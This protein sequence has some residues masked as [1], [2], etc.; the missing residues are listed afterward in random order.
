MLIAGI[1]NKRALNVI[2]ISE[3]GIRKDEGRRYCGFNLLAL[4]FYN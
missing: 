4:K 2:M 3:Y 1:F